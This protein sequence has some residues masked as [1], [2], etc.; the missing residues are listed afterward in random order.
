MSVPANERSNWWASVEK[1]FDG[2]PPRLINDANLNFNEGVVVA[3][4]FDT[5]SDAPF[6]VKNLSGAI[7]N[8]LYLGVKAPNFAQLEGIEVLKI[9]Y[10]RS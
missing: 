4:H 1:R 7:L 3:L 2:Y 9:L 6:V 10:C 8:M 5:Q